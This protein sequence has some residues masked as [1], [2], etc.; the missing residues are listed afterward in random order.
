MSANTTLAAHAPSGWLNWDVTTLTRNWATGT[1][2]NHGVLI[3]RATE[4]LDAGGPEVVGSSWSDEPAEL[5]PKLE[6][7]YASDQVR[8]LAP[9]TLHSDGA[10]LR[11]EDRTARAA[12][13]STA[14][15]STVPPARPSPRRRAR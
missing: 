10:D 9:D 15:R 11:W 1:Q 5:L 8:L 13:R 6:V 12:P 14:T 4:P 3:K 2:P 7:T